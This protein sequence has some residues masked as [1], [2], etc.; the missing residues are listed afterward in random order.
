MNRVILPGLNGASALGFLAALGLLRLAHGRRASS[1][2]GFLPDGSF[3]A[4]LEGFDDDPGRLV[5]DD[6]AGAAGP[7]P[8][9]LEYEK[10]DKRGVKTVADLKA[11][12]AAFGTY[13]ARC[14]EEWTH[15]EN[16]AA[17]YAA[18]FGTSVAVD[19]KGNTKPTA[20]HF[21]AANQQFLG[22][23]EAIRGYVSAEWATESLLR[24]HA[25][26]PGPNLRWDPAAE[27]NWA[28]MAND[29]NEEGTSVD[30][31]LEWLTFRAL[32]MFP[33]SPRG[34]RVFTTA[35]SGR[36]EDMRMTWPLWST[37]ASLHAVRTA[38]QI[39]WDGAPEARRLR[40]VFAVCTSPIRRTAQGFGN[41]GPASVTT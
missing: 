25:A 15:G 11:P 20:F 13:L 39:P 16:E 9:R 32:P 19:G 7:Q 29:P 30:A 31:P 41:F 18:A 3:H 12:P 34:S 2:L 10:A 4:F 36:G 8:W 27:R 17:S 26:R 1:M 6:A 14:L 5:A 28:L 35:V 33:T 22:T 37:P 38:L 40:G 24:G 23:V 21:T